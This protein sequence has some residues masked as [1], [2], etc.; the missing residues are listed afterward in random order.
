MYPYKLNIPL[1]PFFFD[2]HY[3][4]EDEIFNPIISAQND[5]VS[6][7]RYVFVNQPQSKNEDFILSAYQKIFDE[8]TEG[9]YKYIKVAGFKDIS[10]QAV[11]EWQTW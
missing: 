10:E 8:N 1:T 7:N 5:G 3:L 11:M 4:E 9:N 6:V 2:K